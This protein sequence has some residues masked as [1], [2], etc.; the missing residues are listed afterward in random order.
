MKIYNILTEDQMKHIERTLINDFQ[1]IQE[2][3]RKIIYA[4]PEDRL[5]PFDY[6]MPESIDFINHCKSHYDLLVSIS[7]LL[8]VVAWKT[9]N[10]IEN[11][12]AKKLIS[13]VDEHI[14]SIDLLLEILDKPTDKFPENCNEI[15]RFI[16]E[17]LFDVEIKLPLDEV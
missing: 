11:V 2:L 10:E 14:G 9:T 15:A 1:A 16:S 5:K 7:I 6:S 4:F 3:G 17:L 8:K 12:I 13:Y